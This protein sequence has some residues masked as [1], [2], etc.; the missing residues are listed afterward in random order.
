METKPPNRV[1]APLL[2]V[3][4]GNTTCHA[5][6]FGGDRPRAAALPAREGLGS[7]LA[8]WLDAGPVPRSAAVCAVGDAALERELH[9]LLTARIATVA[10]DP[11]PGLHLDV[12]SPATVG[13]DRLFAA[14]GALSLFAGPTIVVDAGT[15]LTVDAV[16]PEGPPGTVGTFLGG[17]IAPGPALL[18]EALARGGARL[19]MVAPRPGAAALGKATED[20]LAAG[21]GVGFEGTVLRLVERI[22]AECGFDAPR[23]AL[24][25]GALEFA[26]GAL[27]DSGRPVQVEPELVGLGLRAACDRSTPR[28]GAR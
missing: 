14:R 8:E 2:T 16:T 21:V 28:A 18:A 22:A 9:A 5:R 11:D 26:R 25:G 24:T 20:A 27:I 17:A 23:I 7:A 1:N 3:D 13:R 4:L 19:P 12:R 6:I 15:A 10:V